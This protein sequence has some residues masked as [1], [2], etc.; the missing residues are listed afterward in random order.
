MRR[1]ARAWN[2]FWFEAASLR[3]LG[4][5][6]VVIVGVVVFDLLADPNGSRRLAKSGELFWYPDGLVLVREL[7][8]PRTPTDLWMLLWLV[9][10][11]WSLLA[12]IG[13]ATRV[14]LWALAVG[15]GWWV[16]TALAYGFVG[17]ARLMS[18]VGLFALA[19]GPSG[20]AFSLD[21]VIVRAKAGRT[22]E[23]LSLATDGRDP[24][25]GWALRFIGV[26]LV[27]AY[28]SA[29]YAK[30]RTSGFDWGFDGAMDAALLEQGSKLGEF[31][32]DYP[33]IV[34]LMASSALVWE[35][36]AFLLL[37]G[38]RARDASV[39]FGVVF[40]VGS[41][42]L[43]QVNFVDYVAAYVVFYR[44]EDATALAGRRM[45]TWARSRFDVVEV[46][47]DGMCGLC[48][49]TITFLKGID[50]LDLLRP[51][52]GAA[53]DGRRLQVF[54]SRDSDKAYDGFRAYRRIV[55]SVPLLAPTNLLFYLP[56]VTRI[57]EWLYQHVAANRGTSCSIIAWS[58]P[59]RDTGA[60][61]PAVGP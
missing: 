34:H 27:I 28:M 51:D 58:V 56:G 12:L 11:I 35:A 61:S 23:P 8:L 39:L 49:K 15:Y 1:I 6:R 18:V 7:H 24:L 54:E 20:R 55:R 2:R 57:G 36:T 30:I 10:V 50:W 16:M 29:A 37:F 53:S 41:F 17:H 14:A 38:G 22:G 25:A 13:L 4:I 60:P 45:R 21:A 42:L 19:I 59:A 46:R 9:L 48:V 31:T 47:Y 43:L 33:T 44:L 40:H 32:A 3:R 5:A 52:D 26:A